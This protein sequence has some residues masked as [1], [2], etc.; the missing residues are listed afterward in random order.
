MKNIWKYILLILA[1]SAI[2]LGV[3][4]LTMTVVGNI[5][6]R[7]SPN[8]TVTDFFNDEYID[9][10]INYEHIGLDEP[11]VMD[12]DEILLRYDI[13]KEYIDPSIYYDTERKKVIITTDTQVIKLYDNDENIT[14]ND[15]VLKLDTASRWINDKLYVPINAFMGIWGI[16]AKYLS[17][18]DVM[19]IEA[20]RNYDY[21][22][23]VNVS[24]AVIREDASIK[25]AIYKKNVAASDLLYVSQVL[26]EWTKVMTK[27]GIIGYIETRYLNTV[28]TQKEVVVIVKE[29]EMK[30]LDS[31]VLSWQ[32]VYTGNNKTVNY[33][34]DINVVSPT[35]F[36]VNSDDGNVYSCASYT[37]VQNAHEMGYEVWPLMNNVFTNREQIGTVLRDSDAREHV[38]KQLLAYASLYGFD[39]INVDF[40][41]LYLTDKENL[42]QFMRELVPYAH[43]ANLCVSIDVGIPGGSE[44]YSLC[45]DHEKLG[46]IVD[47]VMVMTYDQYWST[48][49][50][51]GSQAQLSWVEVNLK[52]TLKLVPSEKLILGI[53]AYTRLWKT[54]EEGKVTLDKTLTANGVIELVKEKNL[55]PIWETE[56]EG[57]ISGQY[58]I[59]YEEEGFIY[60]AWIED[61]NSAR[62]K[63]ELAQKYDLRGVCI[64]MMSQTN[65]AVW[66]AICEGLYTMDD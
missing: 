14:I 59:E 46:Q 43:A 56:H 27:E 13:I 44:G 4:M 3:Y 28:I 50:T 66:E 62:V 11:V 16:N 7:Y 34:S 57:F 49:A 32:H 6:E 58:Y 9:L 55:V 26:G 31:V 60:R 38:I 18:T 40:E 19:I 2:S 61:E 10:N 63:A 35:F 1:I 47:Y 20:N 17:G 30:L 42:V 64:W 48:H 65:K 15:E 51:G 52:R 24:D 21:T 5:T 12:G 45:Y 25:S 54:D 29:Q 8:E 41:N 53:P 37:Y 23:T 36:T 22:A 39:G 33:Y